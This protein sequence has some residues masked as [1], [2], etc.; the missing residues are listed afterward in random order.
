MNEHI[1][2]PRRVTREVFRRPKSRLFT[3]LAVVWSM[4]AIPGFFL[5]SLSDPGVRRVA[6]IMVL[7]EPAFITFAIVF[8]LTERPRR[9]TEPVDSNIGGPVIY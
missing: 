3:F 7:P 8:C 1:V 6:W 9:V 2:P 4:M 5:L